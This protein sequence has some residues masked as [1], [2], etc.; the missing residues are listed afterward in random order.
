MRTDSRCSEA[1]L[2]KAVRA[3]KPELVRALLAAGVP[4]DARATDE[5]HNERGFNQSSSATALHLACE[6]APP[7][8]DPSARQHD[9]VMELLA[10]GAD[11]DAVRTRLDQQQV[12]GHASPTDDP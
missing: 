10:H 2:H 11:V 8:G 3:N 6:L 12:V 4:V 1:P 7:D 9:I 5:T